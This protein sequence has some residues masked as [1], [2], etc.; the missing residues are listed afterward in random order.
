MANLG[1]VRDEFDRGIDPK[2]A[3]AT[4]RAVHP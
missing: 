1:A 4:L 2:S 3:S